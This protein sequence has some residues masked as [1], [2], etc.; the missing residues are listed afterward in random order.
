MRPNKEKVNG[1][2]HSID[3]SLIHFDKMNT[4]D[5]YNGQTQQ[6]QINKN[7]KGGGNPCYL[8]TDKRGHDLGKA[9]NSR[10]LQELVGTCIAS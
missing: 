6:I 1:L 4:R 3:L 8:A 7:R 9:L 5:N 2:I 10:T